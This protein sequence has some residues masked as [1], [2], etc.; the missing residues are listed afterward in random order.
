LPGFRRN[1]DFNEHEWF[2]VRFTSLTLAK[3]N[4]EIEIEM[5]VPLM[6]EDTSE[7]FAHPRFGMSRFRIL[8][9]SFTIPIRTDNVYAALQCPRMASDSV[10]GIR[11]A[12]G[13]NPEQSCWS[14]E[15]HL[16]QFDH[17]TPIRLVCKGTRLDTFCNGSIDMVPVS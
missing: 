1:I 6:C 11:T 2:L 8:Q 10:K 4:V 15:V 3:D 9:T 17:P 5:D 16:I 13:W 14:G 7:W 12:F